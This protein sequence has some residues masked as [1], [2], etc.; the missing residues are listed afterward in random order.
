MNE[1][2]GVGI[3]LKENWKITIAILIANDKI[4][5]V[6]DT[7]DYRTSSHFEQVTKDTNHKMNHM[8]HMWSH[9]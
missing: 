2:H 3:S 4:L 9:S 7:C 8:W 1:L 6:N 5:V